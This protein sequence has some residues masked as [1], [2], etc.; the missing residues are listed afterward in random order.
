MGTQLFKNLVYEWTNEVAPNSMYRLLWLEHSSSYVWCIRLYGRDAQ[1]VVVSRELLERSIESGLARVVAK[2][3]YAHLSQLDTHTNSKHRKRRDE[4]W[5]IVTAVLEQ[6]GERIFHYYSRKSELRKILKEMGCSRS[7]F[8]RMLRRFLQRGQ[9]KN[10]LF[11][12]YDNCGW[13]DRHGAQQIAKN[14]KK[15]GR[16][17]KLATASGQSRGVNI[18]KET[19]QLFKVGIKLFYETRNRPRLSFAFQQTLKRFFNQ[20]YK[21]NRNGVLVPIMPPAEDLPT[22]HQFKYWYQKE[23]EPRRSQIARDGLAKHNLRARAKLGN[24][25]QLAFGP[26][27]MY[28]IDATIGDVY[29]V[30]S[31]N[32]NWI[33]G[34]PVIYFIIDLFSRLIVGLSVALE[35]PSWVGAMLALENAV[36]DK[37]AF[38]AEYDIS[39]EAADW[40][41]KHLPEGIM[42]DRG[43]FEGYNADQLVNAFGINVYNTAPYRADLKGVVE[44]H[45]D[46]SNEKVI[47]WMPGRVRKRERGDRDY[48]LDAT[49]DL[50]EFRKIV[51]LATL[52]HN[53]HQRLDDYP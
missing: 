29:L 21:E 14:L 24:S 53:I 2:D 19:L 7:R 16:P 34:R 38:C 15:L 51:I 3:P 22:L 13:R 4:S 26:G 37:V 40:P 11:P 43:E 10:A 6:Y 18:T 8:F 30:S 27:S 52:D 47:H 31:L 20:G 33:I 17:S 42:A 1:P 44:Q 9:I 32:R 5:A 12:L 49:L 36:T 35:G 23:R 25:T 39:I 48:R 46:R 45:F 50:K 28:Q 41:I